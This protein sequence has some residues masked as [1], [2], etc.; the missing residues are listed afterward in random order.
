MFLCEAERVP[1]TRSTMGKRPSVFGGGMATPDGQHLQDERAG[2]R[3]VVRRLCP[4]GGDH[5]R[6]LA[7]LARALLAR[8]TLLTLRGCLVC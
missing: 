5:A 2:Q 7:M 8:N 4:M 1:T 3:E 6:S